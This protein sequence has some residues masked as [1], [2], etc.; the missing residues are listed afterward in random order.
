LIT[1]DTPELVEPNRLYMPIKGL[2]SGSPELQAHEQRLS[3]LARLCSSLHP[4]RD[5]LRKN[6]EAVVAIRSTPFRKPYQAFIG[7]T[8]CARLKVDDEEG[9][10][11]RNPTICYAFLVTE[12]K[13]SNSTVLRSLTVSK[14]VPIPDTVY[15]RF[16]YLVPK[17][18]QDDQLFVIIGLPKRSYKYTID[19]KNET[20]SGERGFTIKAQTIS[21]D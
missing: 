18:R 20:P 17:S 2:T 3:P 4:T 12:E 6:Q 19:D 10:D 21:A 14:P 13:D 9:P 15:Q 1:I 7:S 11:S 16:E 8:I 5:P